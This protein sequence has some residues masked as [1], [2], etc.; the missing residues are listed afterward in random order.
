MM[1][2]TDDDTS[3]WKETPCSWTGQINT[4]KM[5]ILPNTI[6]RFNAIPIKILMA[7]FH[8]TAMNILKIYM[9]T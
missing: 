1:K 4:V 8:T 2:E 7:F 3:R 5:I 6:C 9:K